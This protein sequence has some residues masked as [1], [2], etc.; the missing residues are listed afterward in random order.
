MPPVSQVLL[1]AVG[2]LAVG[3]KGPR[4]AV[5]GALET[6]AYDGRAGPGSGLVPRDFDVL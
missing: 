5:A 3:V 2:K 4:H 6:V 1:V